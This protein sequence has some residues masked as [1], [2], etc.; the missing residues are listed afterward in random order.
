MPMA[1]ACRR[2]PG[3]EGDPARAVDPGGPGW[4]DEPHSVEPHSVEWT[5]ERTLA[6]TVVAT[7][8][9]DHRL[10]PVPTVTVEKAD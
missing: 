6:G 9:D 5:V 10:R 8:D 1:G 7:G 4:A 2:T 3:A